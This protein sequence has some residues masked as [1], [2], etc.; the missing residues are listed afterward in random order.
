MKISP[1]F[2]FTFNLRL[3]LTM[4]SSFPVCTPARTQRYPTRFYLDKQPTKLPIADWDKVQIP[5]EKD[6]NIDGQFWTKTQ[7]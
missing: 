3:Y 1:S 2:V 7:N 6:S 5:P 4:L